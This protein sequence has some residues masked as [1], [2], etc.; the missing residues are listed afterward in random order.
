MK[1]ITTFLL[2]FS[3]ALSCAQTADSDSETET[4][5]NIEGFEI[6]KSDTLVGTDV[7]YNVID[8]VT[9]DTVYTPVIISLDS[10][11][12]RTLW[13]E[14]S[15]VEGDN[16]RRQSQRDR[17]SE[18]V[19]SNNKRIKELHRKIK[20]IGRKGYRS[21]FTKVIDADEVSTSTAP[22]LREDFSS[23]SELKKLSKA[24]LVKMAENRGIPTRGKNKS[25]LAKELYDE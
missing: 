15:S 2:V 8:S 16:I 21:V 10:L 13:S 23:V 25:D 17:L 12:K 24:R 6:Q 1:Y 4:T 14:V 22:S 9:V 3:V 7:S 5:I 20:K 11:V 18:K 19:K